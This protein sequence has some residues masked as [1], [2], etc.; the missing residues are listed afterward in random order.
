MPESTQKTKKIPHW[1]LELFTFIFIPYLIVY[2]SSPVI[3]GILLLIGIPIFIF[4][5]FRLTNHIINLE[6]PAE[7]KKL[8]LPQVPKPEEKRT[9]N[10]FPKRFSLAILTLI[11]MTQ[12]FLLLGN[13]N[14]YRETIINLPTTSAS[15]LKVRN[16]QRSNLY[17][18]LF[19]CRCLESYS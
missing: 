11:I 6:N 17:K 13:I 4:L 19:L 3:F 7:R 16:F 5:Y 14:N 18:T 10:H 9:K 8:I 15:Q 12:I 2:I 1:I